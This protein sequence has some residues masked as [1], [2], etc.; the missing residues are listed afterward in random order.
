MTTIRKHRQALSVCSAARIIL[1]IV[2]A[3]APLVLVAAPPAYTAATVENGGSVSGKALFTGERP[4]SKFKT[5]TKDVETCGEGDREFDITT[6]SDDNEMKDVVVYIAKI[7]EGK[8]W[9]EQDGPYVLEQEKCAFHPK[10]YVVRRG[11]ELQV[12]N[13]DKVSHNIHTYEIVGRARITM[14]NS[15]Q[16]AGSDFS[17]PLTLRRP[18][19]HAIKLEC[20]LHNFMHAWMFAA[21]NPYYSVTTADGSFSIADIPPGKYKFVAW[22]PVLGE[23]KKFLEIAAGENTEHSFTFKSKKKKKKKAPAAVKTE[24]PEQP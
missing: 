13:K 12:F 16:P 11:A 24:A 22:H 8:S 3:A 9:P 7:K 17:K 5:I 14:F 20:D 10:D 2:V 21:D 18:N 1:V 6:I 23:Q 19:S 4:E 15:G